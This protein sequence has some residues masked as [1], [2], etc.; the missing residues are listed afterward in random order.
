MMPVERNKNGSVTIKHD[1]GT[2][3]IGRIKEVSIKRNEERYRQWVEECA[4]QVTPGT[5]TLKETEQHFLQLCDALSLSA[6]DRRVK[7]FKY[8]VIMNHCKDKLRYKPTEFSFHMTDEEKEKWHKEDIALREELMNSS[9][10]EFG[11]NIRGYYLPHTERNEIFYEEAYL[12][13]QEWMKRSNRNLNPNQVEMS[14]IYFFFE[15]ST[16]N[17]QARGGGR[18]L[19]HRLT[20]FKGVSKEDIEKRNQRFLGYISTLREMGKLPDFMREDDNI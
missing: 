4:K 18:I 7:D 8:S 17:W 16:G 10:E 1:K 9:H 13:S 15:E 3:V 12:E 20:V 2:A 5:H 11:L 6:D 19:M 14:D